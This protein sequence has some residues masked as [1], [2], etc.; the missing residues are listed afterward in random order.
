MK[1]VSTAAIVGILLVSLSLVSCETETDEFDDGVTV[2]EE[3]VSNYTFI[4]THIF[5]NPFFLGSG[6]WK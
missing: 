2:E 6:C 3:I 5:N 4:L 1:F